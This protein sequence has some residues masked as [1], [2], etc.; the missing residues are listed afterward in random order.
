MVRATHT[1]S[2][3]PPAGEGAERSE[4]GEGAWTKR[5]APSPSDCCATGPSLSRKGERGFRGSASP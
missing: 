3:S 1:F 5:A 2:P 4:A